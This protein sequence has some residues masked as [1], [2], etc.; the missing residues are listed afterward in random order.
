[1]IAKRKIK[2]IIKWLL[3]LYG[4][5]G[6]GLYYLQDK[7]IFHPEPI[8]ATDSF[9]FDRPFVEI[10]IPFNEKANLNIIRFTLEDSIRKGAVLYYHG[11]MRNVKY[12]AG[13]A[14]DFLKRGYEVWLMDYPGYGKSTGAFDEQQFYNYAEQVYKLA[15]TDISPDSI[16]IYGRS[17]GTGFAAYVASKNKAKLIIL[18]TPYYSMSSLAGEYFPVYPTGYIVRFK[19]HTYS[20]IEKCV[21]PVFIF[22]GTKDKTISLNNALKLKPYLK[23][24][25]EFLI[26]PNG[27]HN[28]LPGNPIIQA[29]FDSLF[30]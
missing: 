29:K 22:H 1:M 9:H 5:V 13:F 15:R 27:M 20:Y 2:S 23:K 24:T 12:Y 10:N 30:K 14:D 28:G 18:E 16:I 25:D 7:L 17:L 26:I 11:N 8:A 3:I 19:V 6:I 4:V 21:M